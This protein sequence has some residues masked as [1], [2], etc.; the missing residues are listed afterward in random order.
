MLKRT[1]RRDTGHRTLNAETPDIE[2]RTLNAER[3]TPNIKTWRETAETS[4]ARPR[5]AI[6]NGWVRPAAERPIFSSAVR[7][8]L[9]RISDSPLEHFALA[10]PCGLGSQPQ[11]SGSSDQ[12][13][14]SLGPCHESLRVII[15][16]ARFCPDSGIAPTLTQKPPKD[17]AICAFGLPLRPWHRAR[18][19]LI[20]KSAD[21]LN[22]SESPRTR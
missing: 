15:T 3:R 12:E 19:S 13:G 18:Q 11:S 17:R 10:S 8:S 4:W 2:R 21:P 14:A 20:W 16:G 6:D 5:W 1:G 22:L 7:I 9:S